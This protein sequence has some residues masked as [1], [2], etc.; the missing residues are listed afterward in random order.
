[1]RAFTGPFLMG[2]FQLPVKLQVWCEES[3]VPSLTMMASVLLRLDPVELVVHLDATPS[4]TFVGGVVAEAA[5]PYVEAQKVLLPVPYTVRVFKRSGEGERYVPQPAPV[6]KG[7]LSECP[8]Q[9][10]GAALE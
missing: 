6:A 7:L 5:C 1:M 2:S 3:H 4:S 9:V 8:A 10:H